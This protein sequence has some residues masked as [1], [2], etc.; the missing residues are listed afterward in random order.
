AMPIHIALLRGTTADLDGNISMEREALTLEAQAVAMAAHNSGGKVLVQVERLA[1][2][3]TLHPRAVRIPGVLVDFIV[4]AEA[5][6]YHMQTFADHYNPAYS[7]ELRVP[8]SAME[9]LEMTERKIIARRAAMELRPNSVVNLGFGIPEGVASVAAEEKIADLMTL[10]AEP[11]AIGGIPAGG[12]DFGA[13]TNAQAI[14]D[15]PYQ[16]DFYDGGGLDAA[17]LGLA[18]ADREGNVNVSRFGPRLAGA[19]GFIDISQ[20]AKKV[21]FLGTFA[22]G[23]LQVSVVEGKLLIERDGQ[24]Q[25]F[26]EEV[27][28]RTFSGPYAARQGKDVLY[29]TERCV[30]RLTTEGL[31]LTEVAPG[32][33]IERDILAK[34]AFKPIVTKPREMDRRI[35]RPDP[36]GLREDMLRLPLD[37]RFSYDDERNILYL[38]FEDLPVKSAEVIEDVVAKIREIC[39]PLGHKVYAVVNYDGFELDSALEDAYL[40]AVQEIDDTY[41]HGVTRFTTSAFMRT[42]L[43]SALESRGV[44]PHIYESEDEAAGA[45][46]TT[47][48]RQE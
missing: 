33:D 44:A 34:M 25:K 28:H 35:F 29:I 36:M 15:M 24:Y 17:F 23:D 3:G 45:V 42:K 16:F 11:G 48:P 39:G 32:I 7:G 38:N 2:R 41:F 47:L 13:A 27:E 9:K 26:V 43:G 20:N 40:D 31:E 1:E 22:A 46:R 37:A 12:G 5:P 8:M 4:V 18:Q 10:T 14:I 30:F 19:G 6:Q 21:L